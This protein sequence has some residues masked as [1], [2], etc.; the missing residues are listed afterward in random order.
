[1]RIY[2]LLLLS[3]FVL[4]AQADDQKQ[5]PEAGAVVKM[6]DK[7]VPTDQSTR[8]KLLRDLFSDADVRKHPDYNTSRWEKKFEAFAKVL[9]QKAE[10][11]KLDAVSLSKALEKNLKESKGETPYIP[12]VVF[13]ADM[14]GRPVWIVVAVTGFLVPDLPPGLALAMLDRCIFVFEQKTLKQVDFVSFD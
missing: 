12:I 1:M 7:P 5:G 11:Q 2:L 14:D 10:E 9:A 13:Q 3:L 8:E 4:A 6:L